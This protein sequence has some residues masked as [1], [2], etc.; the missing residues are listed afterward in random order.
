VN[1]LG[2][3]FY[4]SNGHKWLSAP[5]GTGF[6]YG[7][8]EKLLELSP[9][10]V[11]AGSLQRVVIGEQIAEPFDTGQ[12]FEFGTRAWPLQGGFG[13]S[14]DWFEK[15]GWKKVYAHIAALSGYL[16]ES[17]LERPYMTLLTPVPF[18][19]S[20]GLTS[21]VVDKPAVHEISKELREKWAMPM[22]V[23]PHYNALRISTAHFNNTD[24]IDKLMQAIDQIHDRQPA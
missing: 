15:I 4:A 3:D 21:F 14:L 24:D 7:K 19:A 22:R 9:A 23:I 6:F 10:H 11:G 8:Q 20:S 13:S 18:V 5:K 1:E 16:K 12:R 17:I 2:C